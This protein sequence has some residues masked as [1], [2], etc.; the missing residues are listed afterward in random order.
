MLLAFVGFGSWALASPLGAS[1]DEDFHLPSIWCGLGE[2]NGLCEEGL[3]SNERGVPE[4]LVDSASCYAFNNDQSAACQTNENSF[5]NTDRGN[6]GG[7]YPPIFYGSMSFFASPDVAVSAVIMRFFNAAL[8]VGFFAVLF[9]MLKPGQRGPLV[10]GTAV[11]I[12]PLGMFIVPSVNPSSWAVLSAA[13][14]WLSLLGYFTTDRRPLRIAFGVLALLLSVMGAGARGDSAVYVGMAAFIVCVLTFKKTWAWLQLSLLPIGIIGLGAFFYLSSSQTGLSLTQGVDS[15]TITLAA[16]LQSVML[17]LPL[18]PSLWVGNLGTWGLGWLDTSMPPAV[19]VTMIIIFGAITFWG[20]QRMTRRKGIALVLLSSALIVV[21]MYAIIRDQIMVGSYLQPR[22]L[23]PMI[24]MFAG[25]VL[26]GFEED[27][28]GLS[29]AQRIV[30]LVGASG[31]NSV[32]LYLNLRRYITGFD[33]RGFNLNGNIEWW[34]A[35]PVSPMTVWIVGSLSFFASIACLLVLITDRV[36]TRTL[37]G[38]SN[39]DL[40]VH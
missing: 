34:W 26:Y 14:L 20:L 29:R 6:F 17:N 19:W 9:M 11:S 10:W 37:K 21:P 8:F 18:L 2:R 25:I 3:A 13:T 35:L 28:L 12:V 22:Y 32:A 36:N 39:T 38:L 30:I 15:P 31:A 4:N 23:L 33:Y 27:S 16:A 7:M 5:V 1:P 24:I 40:L